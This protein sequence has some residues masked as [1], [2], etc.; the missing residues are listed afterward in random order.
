[1]DR[2]LRLAAG[3]GGGFYVLALLAVPLLDSGRE[4]LRAHPEDCARGPAGLLVNLGYA[5]FALALAA[6]V[7]RFARGR[8]WPALAP[9]LLLPPA[10]LCLA[11]AF[12]PVGL[13]RAGTVVTLAILGLVAGPLATS[14]VV[15][16]RWLVALGAAVL[17]AFTLL[18]AAPEAVGGAVNRLFD[19]LAGLWVLAAASKPARLAAPS[20]ASPRPA[21]RP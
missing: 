10:L 9:A 4:V 13:A 20:G 21:R 6:T 12:D 18:V 7:M 5:A 16:G 11:L 15:R 2:G 3:L 19:V 17:A 14:L 1:M 8:R